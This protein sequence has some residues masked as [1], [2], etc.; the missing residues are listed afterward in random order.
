VVLEAGMLTKSVARA[1]RK[2]EERNF[3]W[4]KNILEYDEPM[5]YQRHS[6]YGMRQPILKSEGIKEQIFEKLENA[7]WEGSSTYLGPDHRNNCIAE[8]ISENFGVEI[9]KDRFRKK[10]REDIHRLVTAETREDAFA[11]IRI[12]ATEFMPDDGDV[13]DIEWSGLAEWCNDVYGSEIT[14]EEIEGMS[15]KQ[16]CD[17]FDEAAE[18]KFSKISL[19][20]LDKFMIPDFQK[21]ELCEW[22]NRK[23]L[24]K[25]ETDDLKDH[26][27]VEDVCGILME[28]IQV[29][30]RV[31]EREYPITQALERTNV[32]MQT[33]PKAAVTNFTSWVNSR[34][35]LNWSPNALPS[36]DPVELRRILMEQSEKWTPERF[37]ER[38]EMIC[39][40]NLDSEELKTWLKQNARVTLT[41]KELESIEDGSKSITEVITTALENNFRSELTGFERWILLQILDASWKDH[42]HQMDQVK[43]AIGFRSFSQKDPRIEFKR[44]AAR[45]YDEMLS[46]VEDKTTDVIMRGKMSYQGTTKAPN[47][48]A[49]SAQPGPVATRGETGTEA[50]TATATATATRPDADQANQPRATRAARAAT[51]VQA[52]KPRMGAASP[53]RTP[54]QAIG[55][56]E[57]VTLINPENGEREEMKFKKAKPLIDQGW[58]L[59]ED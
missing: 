23:F 52:K 24:T 37:T 6:F 4:R 29:V 19:E 35:D 43:D 57:M 30:Y 56:N 55:R 36:G 21:R 18:T 26:D 48:Q 15:R 10:D 17:R 42:L 53:N 2:V 16:V 28:A 12:T 49:G 40:K 50:A 45:L 25:L 14:G 32:Q 1:Q 5:E 58:R 20:P 27:S 33:D 22:T 13:E 9:P 39:E 31:R 46:V 11:L 47:Q 34:Y 7:V 8:W 38:A 54:V 44:E 59:A 3:Q 51:Q 41:E